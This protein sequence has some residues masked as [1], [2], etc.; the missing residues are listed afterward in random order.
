MKISNRLT[1]IITIV[2]SIAFL[3]IFTV[4]SYRIDLTEDNRYSVSDFSKDLIKSFDSPL[5]IT[6]YLNGDFNTSFYQ[7]RKSIIDYID[8]LSSFSKYK[9]SVKHFNS[10]DVDT[11][12]Q[13]MAKFNYL[14]DKGLK[15]T[16]ILMRDKDGNSVRKIIFPWIE[17]A[18][19]NQSVLV[20]V[21]KNISSL[22]GEE[23]INISIENIEYEISNALNKLQ[24]KDVQK[25]AFL[26]GHDE[27]TEAETYQIM[28]SLSNYYQVD[29]GEIEVDASVLNDYDVII[30]AGPKKPFS[31]IEKYIIDQCIMYGGRVIWLIDGV[32]L[33]AKQ[34]SSEGYSPAIEA[35]INLNDMF[36][37]YGVKIHPVLIQDLQCASIPV[38]IAR[39]KE[40]PQFDIKSWHYAPFLLSSDIHAV[41]KNV[42]EIKSEFVSVSSVANLN[43]NLSSEV[44]LASSS[45]S[46]IESVPTIINLNNSD[47]AE[48]STFNVSHIPVALMV[49]GVF[50]S[51]YTNRI[52]PQ[53]IINSL[54]FREQSVDTKQLFIASS[55]II[56]NETTGIASDSTTL[57]LGY[58]RVMNT[59][60]G[61]EQFI[62]NAVHYLA[63]KEELMQL[64]GK[65]YKARLLS[66]QI[67]KDKRVTIQI[68]NVAMPIILVSILAVVF[69]LRRRFLFKR[70]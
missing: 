14:I 44:L 9:I 68:I 8:D 56:R 29:R 69:S 63:G 59:N 38:N 55:S 58:D 7:L 50:N 21:L 67:N 36:F 1:T 41:T 6:I 18:A 34:L 2:L 11:E 27:L 60:F 43:S 26:E 65:T 61:N 19:D 4:Y 16:E 42:G 39:P 20:P 48:D 25:I 24:K 32:R 17:I 66:K 51:N 46:K 64:R 62:V 13:R 40:K 52:I 10:D 15:P 22:S 12:E 37:R 47:I 53:G 5:E 70:K 30:I 31:E 23:N 49:N 28:K 57:S 45:Y 3:V 33:D 35:D 54:P